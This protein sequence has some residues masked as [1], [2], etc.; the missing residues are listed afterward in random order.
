MRIV[1][2]GKVRQFRKGLPDRFTDE[3]SGESFRQGI[4]RFDFRDF[5]GAFRRQDV[6]RVAHAPTTAKTLEHAA[7][8]DRPVRGVKI[9]QIVAFGVEISD[10]DLR[11]AAVLANN[12]VGQTFLARRRVFCDPQG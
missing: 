1:P 3:L 2:F 10:G 7:D 6:V 5:I 11:A 4:D 9:A 8:N 12:A